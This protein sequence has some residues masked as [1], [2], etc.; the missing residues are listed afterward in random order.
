M[1]LVRDW[2]AGFLD[3]HRARF[4]PHD[5]PDPGSEEWLAYVKGWITALKLREVSEPLA[6][7][8]SERLAASPPRFRAD[9]IPAILGAVEEI[10]REL[11][12]G[13][14]DVGSSRDE[15]AKAS[16]DCRYCGGAGKRSGEGLVAVHHASPSAE[17]RIAPTAAAYCV[18]PH[19]RWIRRNHAEHCPEVLKGIVDL[20]RVLEGGG[21]YSLYP[22]GCKFPGEVD[23]E[24]ADA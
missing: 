13:R 6:E 7:A 23:G 3:R 12:R 8:A 5:W 20:Q 11:D 17:L 2:I 15:A 4:A 10:R 21:M 24:V 19:G 16:K 18:C 22:P 9:H 1:N 14:G